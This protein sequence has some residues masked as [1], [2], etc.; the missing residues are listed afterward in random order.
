MEERSSTFTVAHELG[1]VS[2]TLDAPV[3][4]LIT[5]EALEQLRDALE[6]LVDDADVRVLHICATGAD[7]SRGA[8][9]GDARL[10]E[11]MMGGDAP[12]RAV[13]RLGRIVIDLLANFPVPTLV[14]ARGRIL[15]AGAGIFTACDFRFAAPTATLGFPEVDR[16]MHLSWG[17][18]PRL[19]T[20]YGTTHAKRLALLGESV[21]VGT[22]GDAVEIADDPDAAARELAKR[23]ATKPPLAVRSITRVL[24]SGDAN[25]DEALFAST[26][27]SEDFREAMSAFMAKRAPTFVGR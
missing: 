18:I 8:H 11:R 5:L 27:A 19:T 26:A 12:R 15:G 14:S 25:V 23:L 1:I 7:F 9:L 17:I 13:A 6:R 24:R 20:A 21:S 22:L 3:G 2:I 16:A 4:N 10:A